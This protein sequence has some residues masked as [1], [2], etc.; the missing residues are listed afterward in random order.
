MESFFKVLSIGSGRKNMVEVTDITD[1]LTDEEIEELRAMV[2]EPIDKD[3][4]TLEEFNAKYAKWR[5]AD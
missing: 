1:G 5:Q 2:E 3:T 4:I